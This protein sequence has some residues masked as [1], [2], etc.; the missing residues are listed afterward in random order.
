MKKIYTAIVAIIVASLTFVLSGCEMAFDLSDKTPED[1]QSHTA[2]VKVTDEHGE[3]VATEMVTISKDEIKEGKNFFEKDEKSQKGETGV[4]PERIQEALENN[5]NTVSATGA[6]TSNSNNTA[7]PSQGQAQNN[8]SNSTAST[9]V[10]QIS[11]ETNTPGTPETP[12]VQDD[13]A[14]L[15]ST[16]YMY[17]GRIVKDGVVKPIK[18]ARSGSKMAV[19]T[20]FEGKQLGVIVNENAVLM[21]SVDEKTYVEFTKEMMK[22]NMSED[23]LAIFDGNAL[24]NVKVLK[25]TTTEKADGVEYTVRVYEDGQKDYYIGKTIIKTAATDGSTLYFDSVSAVVPSSVFAPPSGYKKTTLDEEG[26]SEFADIM[27]VTETHSHDE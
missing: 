16:Q 9:T 6:A 15:A 14:V 21:L 8:G 2:I 5:K 13:A 4:S 1:T 25:E 23:E 7:K 27:D 20:D 24:D 17:T 10:K 12:Y 26:V 3:V 11:G 22:E 18:V 19:F